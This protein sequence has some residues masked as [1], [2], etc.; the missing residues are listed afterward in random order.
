M[1]RNKLNLMEVIRNA[2]YRLASH[3]SRTRANKVNTPS[4][5]LLI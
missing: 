1:K 3:T 5:M 4:D 2:V